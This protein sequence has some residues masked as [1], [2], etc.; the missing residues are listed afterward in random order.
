MQSL[1]VMRRA[2]A[3]GLLIAVGHSPAT[4]QPTPAQDGAQP[5]APSSEAKPD[6]DEQAKLER[7][8]KLFYEGNALRNAGDCQRALELYEKSRALVVSVPNTLNAAFCLEQ[9]GR[10]ANALE[11]HEELLTKLGDKLSEA[12]REAI[13]RSMAKLRP[14]VGSIDVSANVT[15]LLVIDGRM[16]GNLP[17][18]APVRVMPGRHVVRVIKDGFETFQAEVKVR[19]TQ[20]VAVDARL[21][22][23]TKAGRLQVE[24]AALTGADLFVDGA[25]VGKLPWEGTL[26]TG[27]HLYW[28]IKGDVGT[29][30]REVTLIEGRTVTMRPSASPLGGEIRIVVN[31]PSAEL[32]LDGVLLGKRSW[33]GRLPTGLHVIEAREEGYLPAR[34]ERRI[35]EK[36]S[37][38]VTLDLK[39]QEDHP[40]WA[41][42]RPAVFFLEAFG[43]AALTTSLGTGAE[44]F[45]DGGDCSENGLAGGLMAGGLVGYE[46]PFRL[47][48]EASAGYLWLAKGV[49]RSASETSGSGATQTN[50]D[51]NYADAIRV[52]GPFVTLGAGYRHELSSS[53]D[54]D[55]HLH[56]GAAL[57]SARDR[58]SGNATASGTTTDAFVEGSGTSQTGIAPFVM[59]SAGMRW[60]KK[61]WHIGFGIAVPIFITNGPDN[62][63]GETGV[64]PCD[65]AVPVTCVKRQNTVAEERSYG[66]FWLLVPRISGGFTF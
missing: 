4:A 19:A 33:Y 43:G 13:A 15:G 11:Y 20:T 30:P 3:L 52:R 17:L 62:D 57:F 16:R 18:S 53:W 2:L 50:V 64:P 44:S 23:L 49:T 40:R 29:A 42:A 14:Q 41:V 36:T 24:A 58:I 47:A 10:S 46:F 48:I 12:D 26:A 38:D 27:R 25:R 66:R 28:V 63:H 56:L 55:G 7:A 35:E 32:T 8:K 37:G 5:A 59:P 54:V 61:P 31:P 34:L 21:K 60:R 1:S 22:R 65:P 45:C 39:V 9:L 51:Y 6:P